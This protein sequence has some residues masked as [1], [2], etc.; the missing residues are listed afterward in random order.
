MNDWLYFK[1]KNKNTTDSKKRMTTW[2]TWQ[3]KQLLP[4]EIESE[5][6]DKEFAKECKNLP[7][8]GPNQT[9]YYL[10]QP[11]FM[12]FLQDTFNSNLQTLDE[13]NKVMV[14]DMI[15]LAHVMTMN[16]QIDNTLKMAGGVHTDRA[17]SDN[18]L[19]M[20][21][22]TYYDYS[23]NFNDV[24]LEFDHPPRAK[25]LTSFHNLN[26][27]NKERIK[28]T[29]SYDWMVKCHK[30]FKNHYNKAMGKWRME[31]GRG[32]GNLEDFSDDPIGR[33]QDDK[34]FANYGPG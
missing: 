18:A 22:Q 23:I 33:G 4:S 28:I 7:Y 3:R 14:D 2:I 31:T 32:S 1:K 11:S 12:T 34:L 16:S 8:L 21:E 13:I 29:R 17:D 27:N 9:V 10:S 24:D 25:Y 19:K 15:H 30:N 6:K 20:E 5:Y 26:P